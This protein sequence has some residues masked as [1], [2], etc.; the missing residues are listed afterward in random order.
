MNL[1]DLI[2][3][4]LGGDMISRI[5]GTLGIDNSDAR[6]AVDATVPALLASVASAAGTTDGA[7]R[8]VSSLDGLD[9]RVIGNIGN[10]LAGGS[11]NSV[12]DTG[13]NLLGSI[14]GKNV[15]S[16]LGGALSRFTGLGA[17]AITSLLGLLGPLVLGTLKG[18]KDRLGL[19]A[20][21]LM[22]MLTGQKQNI[23]DAMPSGLDSML[24]SVPGLSAVTG[25]GEAVRDTASDVA[26]SVYGAGRNVAHTA[27]NTASYATRTA[28]Q[29]TS[30]ALRWLVPLAAVLGIAALV[31][32]LSSR[33]TPSP[34][35]ANP[36]TITPPSVSVNDQITR[37]T[38]QV[39]DFFS[40]AN[41]TLGEITDQASAEAALPKLRELASNFETLRTSTSTVPVA[42]R[43]AVRP[44]V[45]QSWSA[46]Q[47]TIDRVMALPGVGS[48]LR[49]VFDQIRTT[50]EA[51][52]RP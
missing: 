48:V 47:S 9:E 11:A 32:W 8:L 33:T 6:G 41:S 46:L 26:G 1:V 5:A 23:M 52:T 25:I 43:D 34:A 35:T 16:S 15:F 50:A 40:S 17:G 12:V 21:G 27:A 37:A 18:Q 19:D 30:S 3:S 45:S 29:S 13:R 36:R 24:S 20:G 14:L 38:G 49:P 31:W 22:K 10:A 44:V 42:V 7:R 39:K 4:Q 2:K 51:F 28:A